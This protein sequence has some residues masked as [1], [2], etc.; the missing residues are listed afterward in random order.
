MKSKMDQPR[1]KKSYKFTILQEEGRDA[2]NQGNNNQ[3]L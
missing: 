3:E 2:E 1:D